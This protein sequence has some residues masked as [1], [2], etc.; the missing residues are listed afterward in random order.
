M[1]CR[2]CI[3]S[4]GDHIEGELSDEMG[5]AVSRHLERCTA[6]AS[7]FAK[8]RATIAL[9]RDAHDDEADRAVS[10]SFVQRALDA[11]RRPCVAQRLS[12]G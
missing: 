1:K 3:D 11:A 4:L 12:D 8:Y 2:E 7:Y 6:C 10:E 9:A 5:K